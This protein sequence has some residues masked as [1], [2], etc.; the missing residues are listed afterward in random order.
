MTGPSYLKDFLPDFDIGEGSYGDLLVYCYDALT[1]LRVG[2]FCSFA[3]GVKALL[4]G[5]HNTDWVT[6]YPFGPLWARP[7]L[8]GHPKS[9]G[10]IIIGNDV[11]IGAEAM[12]LSGVTIGDGAVIGAR[13]V[14]TRDVKPY[15]KVVGA[16]LK[17]VGYRHT[18]EQ[19]TRLLR[20]QWWNWPREKIEAALPLLLQPNIEMFLNQY[21]EV[22]INAA[23]QGEH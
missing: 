5:E 4:G 13:A 23:T 10:D 1:K 22:F 20:L 16:P 3:F 15:E 2:K 21:D 18:E 8:H 11:W 14:V 7:D 19:R 17:H 6:T 9:Y 12:I